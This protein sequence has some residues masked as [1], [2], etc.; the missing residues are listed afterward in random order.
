MAGIKRG[1]F[2]AEIVAYDKVKALELLGKHLG[3]FEKKKDDSDT[4]AKLDE[5]LSKIGEE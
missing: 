4:L 2:G 1:K 5:V 3:I